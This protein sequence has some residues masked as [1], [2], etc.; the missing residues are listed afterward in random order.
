MAWVEEE[1]M[2]AR[3]V[4]MFLSLVSQVTIPST[5]ATASDCASGNTYPPPSQNC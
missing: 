2:C 3:H 4:V 5:S 1:D